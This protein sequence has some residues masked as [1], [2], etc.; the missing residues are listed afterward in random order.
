MPGRGSIGTLAGRVGDDLA[1]SILEPR[2]GP[3]PCSHG[4]VPD[5]HPVEDGSPRGGT[6]ASDGGIN[7]ILHGELLQP[8]LIFRPC[9]GGC[10]VG[11]ASLEGLPIGLILG[12]QPV[13]VLEPQLVV[14]VADQRGLAGVASGDE[15]GQH[16][17][18]CLGH[19]LR[20]VQSLVGG[21]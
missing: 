13:G 18:G 16:A 4:G 5:D 21:A 12:C 17:K 1:G 14:G 3:E 11:T 8:E 6:A 10:F 2:E 19:S 20:S 7:G 9:L 15:V